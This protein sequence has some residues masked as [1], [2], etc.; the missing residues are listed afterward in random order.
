MRLGWILRTRVQFP[1]P[2]YP[3][4]AMMRRTSLQNSFALFRVSLMAAIG[5]FF[6]LIAVSACT[7]AAFAATGPAVDIQ[8]QPGGAVSASFK[9]S[10]PIEAK[11]FYLSN[12]DRMVVDVRGAALSEPAK[13]IEVDSEVIARV[14]IAQ[15]S[16]E[17]PVVR[18]VFD[19]KKSVKFGV[20][21]RSEEGLITVSETAAAQARLF[22]KVSVGKLRDRV[23][24]VV[25]FSASPEFKTE[26]ADDP[27]RFIVD[28]PGYVPAEKITVQDVNEGLLKEVRVSYFQKQPDVTRIVVETKLPARV[29][30]GKRSDGKTLVISVFQSVLYGV[31]IAVDPGH[32]GKDPGTQSGDGLDEKDLNLAVALRLRYLLESAGA[33]VVMT[34]SD[35]VFI[36]LDDRAFIANKTGASA[37]VSIHINALPN[38]DRKLTCRGPQMFYHSAGSEEFARIMLDELVNSIS[39]SDVGMFPR[40]FAVLRKTNMPAVLAELGFITH[41]D[42]KA[43]LADDTFK[44]NVA[45]GLFNGL[46]RRFGADRRALR[47]FALAPGMAAHLPARPSVERQYAASGNVLHD[48]TYNET[49]G[50][51]E[52]FGPTAAAAEVDWKAVD[53]SPASEAAPA[54]RARIVPAAVGMK[55]GSPVTIRET[56]KAQPDK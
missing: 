20:D 43:L 38:H 13:T 56:A 46:E 11:S 49:G 47:P 27:P 41:P 30:V 48:E 52:T 18:L 44:D 50:A 33:K 15:N 12:P 16:N 28:F 25:P 14:R 53:A 37:F 23:E 26:T 4:K 39:I 5:A 32:G 9:F 35:D 40:N 45:R 1:P 3:P 34:R 21:I 2:P 17:P 29:E 36:S 22:P 31:T 54:D 55:K 6:A 7:A 10:G 24:L 51:D 42:D 19:M 8:K